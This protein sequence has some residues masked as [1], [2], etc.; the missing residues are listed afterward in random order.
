MQR[1]LTYH[2][3]PAPYLKE[4]PQWTTLTESTEWV[5][6]HVNFGFILTDLKFHCRLHGGGLEQLN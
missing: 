3:R 5:V 6:G 2:S 1:H 4:T